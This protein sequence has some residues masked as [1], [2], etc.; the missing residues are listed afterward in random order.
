MQDA[1]EE[2]R[3]LQGAAANRLI[4]DSEGV[5]SAL[6]HQSKAQKV[7]N[8]TPRYYFEIFS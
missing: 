3:D 5:S 7:Q 4:Q 2:V 1:E 8:N 6:L